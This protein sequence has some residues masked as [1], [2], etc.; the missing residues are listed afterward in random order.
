M[1]LKD[2]YPKCKIKSRLWAEAIVDKVFDDWI[3]LSAWNQPLTKPDR[4]FLTNKQ[5][6]EQIERLWWTL[7]DDKIRITKKDLQ[8]L[9]HKKLWEYSIKEFQET[10]NIKDDKLITEKKLV[11]WD[12]IYISEWVPFT[13]VWYVK[14]GTILSLNISDSSKQVN[15]LVEDEQLKEFS[16]VDNVKN[17]ID[18][19]RVI[20]DL[21]DEP[22]NKLVL[23]D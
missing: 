6:S 21:F 7:L 15:I 18:L 20:K 16:F 4:L 10:K 19:E 14:E 3:L 13:F 2:L 22:L 12:I 17:L 8:E 23:I 5:V 1:N 11:E 9:V